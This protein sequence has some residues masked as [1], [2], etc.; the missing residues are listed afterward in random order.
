MVACAK[1][2]DP[3]PEPEYSI[4]V[5]SGGNGV[6]SASKTKSKAGETITLTAVADDGYDFDKWV[7]VSGGVT[8]ANNSFTMPAADV[9]VRADFKAEPAEPVIEIPDEEL[10][11][12]AFADEETTG[13]LTFTA[14]AAW[15]IERN[16][17]TRAVPSWMKLFKNGVETYSG[18]A[19]EVELDIVVEPNYTGEE[20]EAEIVISSGNDEVTVSVTQ[21]ATTE[22]G[23]VPAD[24]EILALLTAHTWYNTAAYEVYDDGEDNEMTMLNAAI[25][26]NEDGTITIE[27]DDGDIFEDY[28]GLEPTFTVEGDVVTITVS[29]NGLFTG[30]EVV[31]DVETLTADEFNF[32]ASSDGYTLSMECVAEEPEYTPEMYLTAH[33]WNHILT[34]YTEEGEDPDEDEEAFEVTFNEDGTIEGYDAWQSYVLEGDTLTITTSED[35]ELEFDIELLTK[36][37]L[38]IFGEFTGT[39]SGEDGDTEYTYTVSMRFTKIAPEPEPES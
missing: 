25:T 26:F 31:L 22:D 28:F 24:P 32:T 12:T 20:R 10:T 15:S 21:A 7:V 33:P 27:G 29:D 1:E 14:H 36:E 11:Q 35:E 8:V 16:E 37:E 39:I 13:K 23:E 30:P 34:V 17:V 9:N 6:A 2:N 18:A 19:G 3:K 4:V 5:S 38:E